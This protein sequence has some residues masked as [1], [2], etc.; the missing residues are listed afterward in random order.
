ME[1]LL[2]EELLKVRP[3]VNI[4]TN[5][6]DVEIKDDGIGEGCTTDV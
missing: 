6:W 3:A 5:Y 2:N 4:R 1:E